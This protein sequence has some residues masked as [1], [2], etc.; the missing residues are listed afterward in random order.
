MRTQLYGTIELAYNC[1]TFQNA[2]L[3]G[4]RQS[5]SAQAISGTFSHRSKPPKGA[6]T[7]LY[8]VCWPVP[9]RAVHVGRGT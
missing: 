4:M 5:L 7:R 3:G 9:K 2:R 6:R 8:A 1:L